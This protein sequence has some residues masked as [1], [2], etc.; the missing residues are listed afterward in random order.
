MSS[1]FGTLFGEKHGAGQASQPQTVNPPQMDWNAAMGQLQANPAEAI[2]K[3]G[4]DVPDEMCN[5]PQ[6]AV[7]HM[8]RTGQIGGPMMQRIAPMLQ[9]MGV[10]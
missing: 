3:A 5:N 2:R 9:R 1:L 10:R 7:M 6:A 8:L 4:Y